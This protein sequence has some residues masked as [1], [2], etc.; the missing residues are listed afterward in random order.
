[1]RSWA[2]ATAA[3]ADTTNAN[4]SRVM[5]TPSLDQVFDAVAFL[6]QLPVRGQYFIAAELVDAE[7][8]HNAVAPVPAG[9]G[10]R[11]D[12][13]LGYS[14]ASVRWHGHADPVALGSAFD[15]IMHVV[16]GRGGGGGGRRS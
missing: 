3:S 12:D 1:M 9:H 4:M 14:I 7:I 15:P 5:R 2:R 16:D 10:V 13:A 11:I 6:A 8:L